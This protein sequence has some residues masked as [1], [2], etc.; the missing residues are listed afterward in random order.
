MLQRMQL[1]SICRSQLARALLRGQLNKSGGQQARRITLSSFLGSR[2]LTLKESYALLDCSTDAELGVLKATFIELAKVYHPDSGAKTADPQMFTEIKEAYK[3][4]EKHLKKKAEIEDR[5]KA[6][7]QKGELEFDIKHTAP[8]HRQYLNYEG[9][10][11]GTP[12]QRQK[13]Y[14]KYRVMRASENLRDYRTEKIMWKVEDALLVKDKREASKAKIRNTM[15]RL[16]EDLILDS[17]AKGEFR[18][19]QGKGKP[20]SQTYHNPLVDTTT[21]NLNRILIDNGYVPEWISLEKEFRKDIR[22]AKERLEKKRYKLGPLPFSP[23]EESRWTMFCQTFEEEMKLVN[24]QIEKFNMIVPTMQ[25]QIIPIKAEF[26]QD[27]VLSDY[28]AISRRMEKEN[29][30]ECDRLERT[31]RGENYVTFVDV[32]KEIAALFR[33]GIPP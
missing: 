19:L 9:I 8:Q 33:R 18:D 10:G 27:S 16:V 25:Q 29:K 17:M 15:D 22:D 21:Q 7:Q 4:I 1:C 13:Q 31:G 6:E 11:Y 32:M 5:Q 26:I 14:E 20:L 23:L 24:K 30:A 12:R 3:V 2:H 28:D